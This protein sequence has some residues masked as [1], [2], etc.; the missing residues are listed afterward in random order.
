MLSWGVPQ[1]L[2]EHMGKEPFDM[3]L[4]AG[5]FYWG[6]HLINPMIHRVST[7]PEV[8]QVSSIV[9]TRFFALTWWPRQPRYERSATYTS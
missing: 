4:D 2:N 6:D 7:N 5:A 8:Y 9:L 3:E 1:V